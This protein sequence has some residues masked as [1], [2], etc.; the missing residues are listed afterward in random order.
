MTNITK[1]RLLYGL[2]ASFI[3]VGAFFVL[4]A[5]VYNEKQSDLPGMHSVRLTGKILSVDMTQAMV[6]G[7]VIANLQPANG[8]PV[9]LA[10]PSMGRNLCVAK[11]NI[12]EV[13]A[14]DS[15]E[16]YG[17]MNED[18]SVT[19]CMSEGHFLRVTDKAPASSLTNT[20]WVWQYT[21]LLSG[22]LT[23]PTSEKF[24]LT[25]DDDKG[26]SSATDCNSMSGSY[27]RD[28]EVL[29]FGPFAM[30]RMFCEGSME[31]IYGE[32]LG[33]TRSF[34]IDGDTLQLHL[35]RDYGTMVFVRK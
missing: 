16:V 24:V 1:D 19:P 35:D 6:D 13:R 3:L 34:V 10:L 30:T 11:D 23:R 31:G 25:L 12:E 15:V 2:I 27:V 20:S 14:G 28:G 4:N 22:E 18:G 33:M 21:E 5:Y 32:Q 17:A 29:S 8:D 9:V 26:V 7:P